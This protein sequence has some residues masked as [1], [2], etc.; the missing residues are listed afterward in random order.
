ICLTLLIAGGLKGL[1]AAAVLAALPFTFILYGMI[2]VLVQELRADRKAMLTALYRRHDE[3]PVGA[4]A[5]EAQLLAEEDRYRR[6]P[7]VVNR[8]INT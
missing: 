1:Q 3:T 2:Y 4:D 7:N 5:F 6:A 8:R